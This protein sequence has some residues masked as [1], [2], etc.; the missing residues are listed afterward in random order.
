MSTDN[1]LEAPG[2]IKGLLA[3]LLYWM[4]PAG[5]VITLILRYYDRR[6]LEMGT[7]PTVVQIVFDLLYFG[8]GIYTII[9]FRKRKPDAVAAGVFYLSLVIVDQVFSMLASKPEIGFELRRQILAIGW[10]GVFIVYLVYG[11]DVR[12][13]I[14]KEERTVSPLMKDLIVGSS[15]VLVA[16]AAAA[17]WQ[18]LD[19][20][21]KFLSPEK[22]LQRLCKRMAEPLPVRQDNGLTWTGIEIRDSAVCF[23]YNCDTLSRE[24]LTTAA[25]RPVVI[26]R[27][28]EILR[29]TRIAICTYD[30]EALFNLCVQTGHYVHYEYNDSTGIPLFT[31][32]LTQADLQRWWYGIENYVTPA[33][34]AWYATVEVPEM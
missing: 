32:D 12:E 26:A 34:T 33:D 8:F 3:F 20:S 24:G 10:S 27:R 5:F 9:G 13:L 21:E 28:D 19:R 7:L 15:A 2:K 31:L 29:H 18:Q 1:Q 23:T 4:I 11:R 22:K 14:P 17:L 25:L 6:W 16:I 30:E